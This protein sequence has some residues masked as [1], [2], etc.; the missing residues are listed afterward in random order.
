MFK[1]T[2]IYTIACVF[3]FLSLNGDGEQFHT[4]QQNEQSP[5]TSTLW[6]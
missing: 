3:F 5:L 4:Y 6:T 1:F 2:G